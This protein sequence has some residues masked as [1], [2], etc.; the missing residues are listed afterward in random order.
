MKK[1]V[2]LLFILPLIFTSC[3]KDEDGVVYELTTSVSPAEGGSIDPSGGMY[4]SGERITLTANPST[5]YDFVSWTGYFS[6]STN[7]LIVTI[8]S[9]IQL[10][11][12]FEKTDSDED[13]V[14][15]D[16]DQCPNTPEGQEVDADGCSSEQYGEL[17]VVTGEAI[18]LTPSSFD[19]VGEITSGGGLPILDRGFYISYYTDVPT[20]NQYEELISLGEGDV[21]SF[22]VTYSVPEIGVSITYRA[23][24]TNANGAILGEPVFTRY[25][26]NPPV[27]N[28]TGPLNNSSYMV[29]DIITISGE[30][31]DTNQ[32]SYIA[33]IY[34]NIDGD[35]INDGDLESPF[36][37]QWDTSNY[38]VGQ[39]EITVEAYNEFSD[40]GSAT[41]SIDL[42]ESQP[43][44]DGDGVTDDTDQCP[45]TPEGDRVDENGCT[46]PPIY[47]DSNGV[48]IKAREWAES[49]DTG[50]IDGTTY[51]VVDNAWLDANDITTADYTKVVTTLVTNM[52]FLFNETS[53]N[54]D[55]SH[56]DV[57]NVTDMEGM[58]SKSSF[59][60]DIS[61]WDVS[62]V[63][64]MS[65]MFSLA[66][67]FNQDLSGWNVENVTECVDFSA[68]TPQWVLPKPSFTN[69]TE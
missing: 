14:A 23:Y 4:D 8:N 32:N 19:L 6:G 1:L 46:I 41:V 57:S 60:Q 10:T 20:E 21:G 26:S 5:G 48:T 11:A 64:D 69:C 63:T 53:F 65:Y 30:V 39:L 40:L 12:V 34:I 51:T 38:T 52:R 3:E 66:N 56:W 17:V 27:V 22:S 42:T 49:G 44:S 16:V 58:F 43:D 37:Y 25:P 36:S 45:N 68:S 59:N 67:N 50:V 24:A 9:D 29:G 28:I 33:S 18:N 54:G 2:Y 13:G 62:N 55:I 31:I 35:R 15:D 7:P 47:L 61:A